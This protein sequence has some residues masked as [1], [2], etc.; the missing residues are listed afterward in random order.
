[1]CNLTPRQCRAARALLGWTRADLARAANVSD[2]TLVDFENGARSPRLATLKR[3]CLAVELAGCELLSGSTPAAQY[4][5][6][7]RL[8]EVAP[9]T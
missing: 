1:M 8:V 5:V 6:G 4:G 9:A 2:R 7:V 3:V